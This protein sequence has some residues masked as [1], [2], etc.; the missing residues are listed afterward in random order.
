[1]AMFTYAPQIK[2]FYS[3]CGG[4]PTPEAANNPLSYKFSWSPRG[5]LLPLLNSASYL[6]NHASY[7]VPG[8]HIMDSAARYYTSRAF[9]FVAYPNR[10]STP[11]AEYYD[12]GQAETVLMGTLH[13]QEF[14]QMVEALVKMGRTRVK[15]IG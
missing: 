14:P 6:S 3:Y 5:V 11:F 7:M 1:M 2:H 4:L 8:A 10:D 9:A 13:Y 12:I 15:R